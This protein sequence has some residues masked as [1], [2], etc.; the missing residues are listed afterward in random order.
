MTITQ[1][2]QCYCGYC[3]GQNAVYK[4]PLEN[5][6]K[7]NPLRKKGPASSSLAMQLEDDFRFKVAEVFC[8]FLKKPQ[9]KKACRLQSQSKC[10]RRSKKRDFGGESGF[11]LHRELSCSARKRCCDPEADVRMTKQRQRGS[12][13]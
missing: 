10:K 6:L 3:P 12:E 8:R 4:K 2:L 9:K 13:R 5:K 11:R 1:Y 7:S